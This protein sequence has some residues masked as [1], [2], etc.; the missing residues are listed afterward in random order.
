MASAFAMDE[1][2]SDEKCPDLAA[3]K[4]RRAVLKRKVT[5]TLKAAAADDDRSK[6]RTCQETVSELLLSIGRLDESINS[7]LI[8]QKD[9]SVLNDE[10]ESQCTYEL[11]AK[12]KLKDL[13]KPI[14]DEVSQPKLKTNY[15][16][17]KLPHLSCGT[18]SGEGTSH[19][20][21]FTFLTQFNNVIGLRDNLT[22]SVKFTYL[23]SYLRGYASKLVEHLS[24]ADENYPIA[25]TLLKDEFLNQNCLVDDLFKKL[26]SIKPK[27]DPTYGETKLFINQVRSIIADLKQN[28]RDLLIDDCC[29]EFVSHIVF[30]KLPI[31]FKHELVVKLNNNF[32][33]LNDIFD[34]YVDVIRTLNMKSSAS[35]S[36]R[37]RRVD[38]RPK[39]VADQKPKSVFQN[40]GTNSQIRK[41][42]K[43]CSSA[44]HTMIQCSRYS[45]YDDR[46]QR[47]KE[48]NL[49][50]KCTSTKHLTDNC[51]A[52]LDYPCKTCKSNSHISAL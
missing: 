7:Y 43:F 52:K 31:P 49:C 27:Y 37:E 35:D 8:D 19:Q 40:F 32:P 50:H 12:T 36:L 24:I 17:L 34:C 47:C 11:D 13:L 20:D 51:N 48:I 30:S 18:F 42:C 38:V 25:L 14:A 4:S 26:L 1:L 41:T 45:S 2:V 44:A 46:V 9:V 28:D 10:I 33:R 5:L 16:D 21:Y 39:P 29:N 15:C 23:K 22:A 6:V 3:L